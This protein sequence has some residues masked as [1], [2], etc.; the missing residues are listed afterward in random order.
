MYQAAVAGN[1]QS[2]PSSYLQSAA[3][4]VEAEAN[5]LIRIT[6]TDPNASADTWKTLLG[7]ERDRFNSLMVSI[8]S[9]RGTTGSTDSKGADEYLNQAGASGTRDKID[10]YFDIVWKL[11]YR[12]YALLVKATQ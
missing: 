3:E 5:E 11:A 2:N 10:K 7:T 1:R 8:T 9:C 12:E 4:A 6:Y